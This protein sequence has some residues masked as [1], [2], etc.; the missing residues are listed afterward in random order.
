M[1]LLG[2]IGMILIGAG[3]IGEPQWA[4]YEG[5]ITQVLGVVMRLVTK[6]SIT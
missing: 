4:I 5:I 3:L 2:L 6:E 1:Q